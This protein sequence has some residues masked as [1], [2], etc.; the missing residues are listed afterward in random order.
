[1]KEFKF[2][3]GLSFKKESEEIIKGLNRFFNVNINWYI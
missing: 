1:M 3:G 2:W